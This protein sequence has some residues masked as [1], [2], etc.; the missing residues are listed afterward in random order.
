MFRTLPDPPLTS[1]SQSTPTS[2]S[3]LFPSHWPTSNPQTGLLFGR[4]AEQSPLTRSEDWIGF[5][6]FQ[7]LNICPPKGHT[8]VNER[9][10]KP[11]KLRGWTR[12]GQNREPPCPRKRKKAARQKWEE[13]KPTRD[14]TRQMGV[15]HVVP[16]EGE[17]SGGTIRCARKKWVRPVAPAMLCK[18]RKSTTPC[19]VCGRAMRGTPFASG[20]GHSVALEQQTCYIE[21]ELR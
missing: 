13:D 5:K 19:R 8:W 9:K 15:I 12:E 1:P 20:G 14:P 2:S 7:I 16:C 11:S 21:M 4:F 6:S 3:L 17:D 10:T 18:I